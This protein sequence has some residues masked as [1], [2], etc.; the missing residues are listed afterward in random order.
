ME[1]LGRDL[2]M[3]RRQL[4]K[5]AAI[6][7]VDLLVSASQR[8]ITQPL[9]RILWPEEYHTTGEF[10]SGL[11]PK[12]SVTLTNLVYLS[13]GIQ[14]LGRQATVAGV[15][16]A[17]DTYDQ[18]HPD[19]LILNADLNEWREIKTAVEMGQKA[20]LVVEIPGGDNPSFDAWKK[21]IT[22]IVRDFNG[23]SFIIGNENNR[24]STC[25]GLRENTG[26]YAKYYLAAAHVIRREAPKSK[27]FPFG[28]AY[29][30][31]GERLMETL[32]AIKDGCIGYPMSDIM[33]G[34]VFHYYDVAGRLPKRV[35]LYQNMIK[36]YGLPP[37]LELME[38]SKREDS[39]VRSAKKDELQRQ[40]VIQNLA[41]ALYF[42]DKKM[43]DTAVWHTAYSRVDTGF[44]SMTEVN[45]DYVIQRIKPAFSEFWKISQLLH[46]G[47]DL[48]TKGNT[49]MVTG[50]T[51]Q[52]HDAV[53]V[54]DN[55]LTPESETGYEQIYESVFGNVRTMDLLDL[56]PQL[57]PGL[58]LPR[59]SE[60]DIEGPPAI[61][62]FKRGKLVYSEYCL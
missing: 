7:G 40:M 47:L 25:W 20:F 21:Y 37:V 53:I 39:F 30:G 44:H 46:H 8:E 55:R 26:L 49:T 4:F 59:A 58:Q 52:E 42:V 36:K 41:T 45:S 16:N 57:P 24:T 35:E 33:D 38:L 43:I 5:L 19:H 56:V 48:T 61:L 18:F 2:N 9:R 10:P 31:S 12:S 29:W 13:A 54:W 27:I 15:F 22:T 62:V 60:K 1:K 50:K 32:D 14:P 17:G 11:E 6:T 34:L 51:S 28:D 3:S 23:A